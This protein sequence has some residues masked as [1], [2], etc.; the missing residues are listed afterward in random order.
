MKNYFYLLSFLILTSCFVKEKDDVSQSSD[1]TIEETST[2]NRNDNVQINLEE[3]KQQDLD[4]AIA[5]LKEKNRNLEM[6]YIENSN[7]QI[8]ESE[9]DYQNALNAVK[10]LDNEFVDVNPPTISDERRMEIAYNQAIDSNSSKAL[11]NFIDTYPDHSEKSFIENK[12]IELE[13]EEIF[14]DANTG[15]MP[16]A[17]RLGGNSTQTSSVKVTNDTGCTLTLRYSGANSKKIVIPV[18][19]TSSIKL[20]SGSYRVTASACGAN[21]AGVENLNGDYSSS[22]YMSR[23]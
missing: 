11:K 3:K 10:Q 6:A 1:S 14:K 19:Q 21:Y 13:V 17:D 23:Y 9:R 4:F 5:R 20:S 2:V 7:D 12:I 15:E 8:R 18:A 16:S 22:F